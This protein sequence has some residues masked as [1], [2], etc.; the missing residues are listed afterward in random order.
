MFL[1]RV[2]D[3]SFA[4]MGIAV[5]SPFLFL[6]A[7]LLKLDSPRGSIL[8]CG[9][10]TGRYGKP[11][12][13]FKFRTMVTNADQ[14]GGS[15]TADGDPRVTRIGRVL[16]KY[17][18]DELPQLLNV[19]VG[20]MS[21]VG[22]RPEVPQYASL[23]IGE[24]RDVLSVRPGITDW[25]SLWDCDEGTALAGSMDPERTYLDKIR[26]VKI[27]LQ[28]EYVRS[29]SFRT[30]VVILL[31]T[32]ALLIFRIKQSPYLPFQSSASVHGSQSE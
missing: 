19:F 29:R 21:F 16:R 25:A 3:F 7:F 20:Q 9:E 2:F 26:P 30:D 18:F 24:E 28:L 32:I 6:I 5:L 12:R 23:L 14:I 8:Y 11:F 1:K 31:R 17:K 22:P 13:I 15:S 10:R 4:M 27:A